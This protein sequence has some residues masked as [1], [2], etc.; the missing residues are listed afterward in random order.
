MA[1]V[2]RRL[3]VAPST[4]RTWDR[5]YG[6][7]PSRHTDGRHRRYGSSDIGRLELMQRALLRGAS[8]AE[9][10]RFALEHM[11]RAQA[12]DL[13]P[14]E[15]DT[16]TEA[17]PDRP[18]PDHADRSGGDAS[19]YL[20]PTSEDT[21]H[22][23]EVPSRLARRLSTAALAMDVGAV[24]RMLADA[25]GE[26]GVL[27]AWSGVIDPVLT[28]LGARWRGVS[29]GAEVEYLLAECVHASLVRATPVLEH[30]RNLRPVLLSCVPEERDSNPAYALAAAL[31]G[32]R[33]GTQL[34]GAPLPAEVLTVA[35]RRSA[36]AAVV[37]WAHRRTVADPRLFTRVS[38]G[39][40]RSRLFACGPGW[41]PATLPDRVELL[42]DLPAAADRVEHVLVGTPD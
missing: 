2:A 16:E 41:D 19:R 1:S 39:R 5:R 40:H 32:R 27:A 7:G 29:A 22:D 6:L 14:A 31:A 36:P 24:Q 4:L 15:T 11:P 21:S 35:V 12:D 34:F 42:P 3:G 23:R 20:P 18:G 13:D 8:T 10:A 38:R 25:I 28:A 26:L 37:L 17:G 9:A 30:P 33:I